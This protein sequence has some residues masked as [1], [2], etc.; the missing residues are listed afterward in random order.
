[1]IKR[2]K[3]WHYHKSLKS[4]EHFNLERSLLQKKFKKANRSG[5][6]FP[7]SKMVEAMEHSV[8]LNQLITEEATVS[9]FQ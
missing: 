7:K 8:K 2:F 6:Y 9:E 4:P 1:M 3:Q 5:H